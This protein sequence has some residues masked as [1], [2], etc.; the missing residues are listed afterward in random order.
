VT[1]HPKAS[2]NA[3]R[4]SLIPN[5]NSQNDERLQRCQLKMTR[6]AVIATFL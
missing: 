5:R 6:M 1:Q 3:Q 2:I 4:D